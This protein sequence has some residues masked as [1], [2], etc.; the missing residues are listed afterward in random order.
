MSTPR[1]KKIVSEILRTVFS[2]ILFSYKD[3]LNVCNELIW[4]IAEQGKSV[5]EISGIM[6]LIPLQPCKLCSSQEIP[7]FRLHPWQ[8]INHSDRIKA[9]ENRP[10]VMNFPATENDVS[11]SP[12]LNVI[13]FGMFSTNESTMKK[14]LA[15]KNQ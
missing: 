8:R 12:Q 1:F 3:F 10:A 4:A 13:Y 2:N 11:G 9:H 15:L 6:V 14:P 5:S 7:G